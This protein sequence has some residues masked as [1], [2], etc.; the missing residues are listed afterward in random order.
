MLDDRFDR[1]RRVVDE[2]GDICPVRL[3]MTRD[4]LRQILGEPEDVG[5]TSTRQKL[6]LIWRYGTTEFHFGP[7]RTSGLQMIFEEDSTGTVRLSIPRRQLAPG[8]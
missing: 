2:T 4:E 7:S 1:W 8:I 5:A 6:P 3:G